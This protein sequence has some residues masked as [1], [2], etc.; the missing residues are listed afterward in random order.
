MKVIFMKLH[1]RCIY[2]KLNLKNVETNIISRVRYRLSACELD[3]W[4]PWLILYYTDCCTRRSPLGHT[5]RKVSKL[6]FPLQHLLRYAL[7]PRWHEFRRLLGHE[8][9]AYLVSRHI[10][11]S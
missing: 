8:I 9:N 11:Q 2:I 3:V 4:H 6:L 10:S 1:I 7:T 5:F